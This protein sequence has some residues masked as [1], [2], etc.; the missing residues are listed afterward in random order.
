MRSVALVFLTFIMVNCTKSD[1]NNTPVSR[2]EKQLNE[3]GN[4]GKYSGCVLIA[5]DEEIL[6]KKAYGYAN[7]AHRVPNTTETKFGTASM[8]KMFTAIAVMQLKEKGVLR[9]DETVG[10][11]LPEYPNKTVRDRVTV[12]Q[13]LTHT[14]G[15][16]DF[17]NTEFEFKAKHTVRTLEDYFSIFRN[18]SL[19]FSPGTKYSYSNAGYIVLGMLIEKLTGET[20]YDYVREHIF[21]PAHMN[22]TDYYETDSSIDNLAEGYIKKTENG[23]W[24]TSVYMKGARGS[25]AGG[26]YTTVTD[27]LRFSKALKNN[28]LITK[29]S[30]ELMLTKTDNNAY[31]YGFNLN[32]F[33]QT[34]VYGHNGGAHGVSAELDIYKKPEYVVVTLSNRGPLDGWVDVRSMIRKTL[35][36]ATDETDKFLGSKELIAI[37]KAEGYEAAMTKLEALNNNISQR[38]LMD[39]ANKYRDQKKYK[40]AIDILNILVKAIP[41]SWYCFSILADTYLESGN[42]TEAIKNYRKSLELEPKNTWAIEKLE[43]LNAL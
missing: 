22:N 14:S 4:N 15:L 2:I 41:D 3:M 7:I 29:E 6:L 24:K 35:S 18:D 20:Y 31:G 27:L 30:L 9:L 33:N 5:K 8:G 16:T 40:N 32:T 23:I 36:G 43:Q 42:K 1:Q 10:E 12:H 19:L 28:L 25:S 38:Y 21:K 17:F 37:Y 13:L 11:I 26:A 39:A 34:E